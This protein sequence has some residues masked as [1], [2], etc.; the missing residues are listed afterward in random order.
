MVIYAGFEGFVDREEL[1]WLQRF[2]NV[3]VRRRTNVNTILVDG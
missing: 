1:C 2:E 3:E